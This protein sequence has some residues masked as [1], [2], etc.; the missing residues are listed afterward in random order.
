MNSLDLAD[1]A[2]VKHIVHEGSLSRAA[3]KM[4]RSQSAMSHKL[5]Q[6]ETDLGFSLFDRRGRKLIL[7]ERGQVL[8]SHAAKILP[9]MEDLEKAVKDA[10]HN[11][12]ERIRVM[13]ACYTTY[14]WLPTV[15]KKFKTDHPT[16]EIDIKPDKGIDFFHLMEEN[17][18]DLVI[19]DCRS[20]TSSKYRREVLFEDEFVLLVSPKSR[21]GKKAGV[22]KKDLQGA[23]LII[24]DV[25]DERSTVLNSFIRPMQIQLNSVT[26]IPLTEGIMEM[27]S[28]D[29]GITIL[30]SWIA[31][32]YV[33]R[34]QLI[35][36]KLPGKPILRKWYVFSH[37]RTTAYQKKLIRLLQSDLKPKLMHHPREKAMVTQPV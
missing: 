27:V 11:M 20:S 13:T 24:F 36:V 29:L 31:R 26:K 9:L 25:P 19:S 6:L 4:F 32:P 28:A 30:P 12:V 35:E 17:H 33:E 15:I 23:D 37:H 18:I 8:F 34:K 2:M 16:V 7:T 21:F 22:S 3:A 14:H 10:R 5:R 1:L